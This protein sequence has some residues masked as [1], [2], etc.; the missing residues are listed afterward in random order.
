[1]KLGSLQLIPKFIFLLYMSFMS[2][3]HGSVT[4][5]TGIHE[6]GESNCEQAC[7]L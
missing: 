1:M 6:E 3:K 4:K 2:L 7:Q 5:D